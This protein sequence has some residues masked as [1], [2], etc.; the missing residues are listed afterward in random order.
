[1]TTTSDL[2]PDIE[3]GSLFVRTWRP[4]ALVGEAVPI[5]LLHD[6]LGCVELWRDFPA[7]L[8]G[9]TQRPVI[10]YDRLGFGRSA[11][12]PGLLGR[13][14]VHAQAHGDFHTVKAALGL[15]QFIVFGHSVGGGQAVILKDCGH[16][17]HREHCDAVLATVTRWLAV[18][19]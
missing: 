16:V 17:P 9:A 5:V 18:P 12:H 15:E 2:Y 6:S 3:H 11:P 10:A 1:M 4:P 13:D 19:P 7:R 14:F 8:A